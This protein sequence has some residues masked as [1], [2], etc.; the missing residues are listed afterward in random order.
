[1]TS[2]MYFPYNYCLL[3]SF[4]SNIHV[5]SKIFWM[6][7]KEFNLS[8]PASIKFRMKHWLWCFLF[9]TNVVYIPFTQVYLLTFTHLTPLPPEQCLCLTLAPP[10]LNFHPIWYINARVIFLKLRRCQLQLKTLS[11]HTNFNVFWPLL[12]LWLSH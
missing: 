11:L 8:L 6:E 3:S 5:I 4:S 2:L 9:S 7:G 10:L 12:S 1:M